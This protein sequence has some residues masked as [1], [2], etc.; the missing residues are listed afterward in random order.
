MAGLFLLMTVLNQGVSSGPPSSL[1]RL[2]PPKTTSAPHPRARMPSATYY[3]TSENSGETEEA[4]PG[5]PVPRPMS[6]EV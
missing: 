5:H 6:S 4:R 1:S 3:Q 2:T